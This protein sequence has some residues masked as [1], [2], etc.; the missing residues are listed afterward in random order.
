MSISDTQRQL[1]R[2][3]ARNCCEYCRVSQSVRLVRFQVDHIIAIKHGGTDDNDNLCLACYKCNSYKGS[4][5][6]AL[7]PLTNNATKLYHPRQQKWGDHVKINSDAILSGLTPEGR[8][9][10]FVLRINDQQR[11]KQRV[12]EM[13]VGDYPCK[14]PTPEQN[15]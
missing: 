7:E 6:A 3:R 10:L 4:N 15:P 8:T 1:V 12:G 13:T 11:V 5:V 9:T 2:E 14:Q